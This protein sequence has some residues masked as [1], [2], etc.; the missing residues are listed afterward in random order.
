MLTPTLRGLSMIKN[1]LIRV[2]SRMVWLLLVQAAANLL[3]G[4]SSRPIIRPS[5]LGYTWRARSD[6]TTSNVMKELEQE[7]IYLIYI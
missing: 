3:S 2:L 1:S 5:T 7:M 4:E 6:V